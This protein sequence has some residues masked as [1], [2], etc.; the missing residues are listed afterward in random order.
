MAASKSTRLEP[1]NVRRPA[2]RD[3]SSPRSSRRAGNGTTTSLLILRAEQCRQL[4]VVALRLR[5]IYG[6][7]VTAERALRLQSGEQDPEIADCLRFGVCDPLADQIRVLE[8]VTSR[9]PDDAAR[10]ES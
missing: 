1:V 9:S 7:A 5:A 4:T 6:I 2:S 8:E 10:T 3:Q